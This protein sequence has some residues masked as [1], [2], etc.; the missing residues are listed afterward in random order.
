[1]SRKRN[2][3]GTGERGNYS[4]KKGRNS[5]SPHHPLSW[6]SPSGTRSEKS[7][8]PFLSLPL[9]VFFI[10]ARNKEEAKISQKHHQRSGDLTV[11][12]GATVER[13]EK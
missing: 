12:T 6:D 9:P 11:G 13:K 1:M 2:S 10:S 8:S 4:A 7:V 3:G 5:P